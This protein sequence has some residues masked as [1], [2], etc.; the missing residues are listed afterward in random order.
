M[1]KAETQAPA[2]HDH[3]EPPRAAWFAT[4]TL[5]DVSGAISSSELQRVLAPVKKLWRR[6]VG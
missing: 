6:A 3:R 4:F 5:L 2:A 1:K